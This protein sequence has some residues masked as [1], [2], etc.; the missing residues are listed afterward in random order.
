M[1]NL[2]I[3]LASINDN[4][5]KLNHLMQSH[6]KQWSLIVKVLGAHEETLKLLLKSP[7]LKSIHSIGV[8]HWETLKL[9]KEIDSSLQTM[10]IKPPA[11]SYIKKIVKYAD[12]SFNSS[13]STIQALNT[14]ARKLGSTHK[15]IVAIEMGEIREGIHRE[16]LIT[17]Y[18][19]VLNL[20]NIEIIGL[21]TNLG[22]MH[23]IR[24]TYD[25]LIQLTLYKQILQYKFHLDLP[26]V[27]GGSS[28]TLPLLEMEKVPAEM[29]HF[30]I[31]EAAFLG[32]SPLNNKPFGDLSTNAFE[33]EADILE[34]YNKDNS[35]DGDVTDA[36]VGEHMAD[37]FDNLDGAEQETSGKSY[38]AVCDFGLLN[39]NAQHLKPMDASIKFFG[40]SSDMTVFDMGIERP[41]YRT[42]D[43]IR[44]KPDYTAVASLMLSRFVIK[45]FV[46]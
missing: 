10:F 19:R 14:E 21:G 44:F 20:S 2:N 42:G 6:N 13:F 33:F 30:R 18:E 43:I 15:V 8:S 41:S 31:G 35:P 7:H 46:E 3:N 32:T 24:P 9:I 12:I 38:K 17:F 29:N 39:V 26:I 45:R 28:I 27:S 34:L 1:T 25:K 16:K 23:G 37:S 4:I 5:N 36:A 11:L 40:N 22:C